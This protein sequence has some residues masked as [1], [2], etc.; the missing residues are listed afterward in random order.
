VI[1]VASRIR[2]IIRKEARESLWK[3]WLS[4]GILVVIGGSLGPMYGLLGSLLPQGLVESLP[5]WLKGPLMQQLH[6]Y[7]TYIWGNWYGKNLYQMLTLLS[8]VF[9]AGLIAGEVSR[10]SAG[11]L[12]SKPVRRGSVL[13]AKY[14]VALA[15]LW[16]SAV[17]G[18]VAAVLASSLA[19]HAV[20]VLWFLTGLPAAMAGT[21]LLLAIALVLSVASRDTVKAAAMTFVVF[22]LLS[23]TAFFRPLRW[24]WVFGHMTAI[25]TLASGQIDWAAVAAMLLASA[26]FVACAGWLLDRRDV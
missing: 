8:V 15:L 14:L 6:S 1:A 25:R 7:R 20:D 12:F 26:L 10:G 19:G 18:T 21:A 22:L 13:R 9:G 17:A 24:L 2:A 23:V 3:I 11:F 4:V 16:A 5:D